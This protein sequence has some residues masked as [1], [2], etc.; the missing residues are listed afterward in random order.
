MGDPPPSTGACSHNEALVATVAHTRRVR[1]L[2]VL[3]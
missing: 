3:R 2:V 1:Y